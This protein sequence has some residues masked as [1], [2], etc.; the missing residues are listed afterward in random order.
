M[1]TYCTERFQAQR[2]LARK[3]A[4]FM[5]VNEIVET[6]RAELRTIIPHAMEACVLLL[7]PDAKQYTRPLQCAL[8]DRPVNCLMCKRSRP[9][10]QKAVKQGKAVVFHEGS[11]VLRHDSSTVDIG[12][13]AAMPVLLNGEVVAVLSVVAVPEGHFS[14]RDFLFLKDFSEALSN[15]MVNARKHWETTKEKI[16]ISQMLAHLAPFVPQSVRTMVETNP[17]LLSQEK[18]PKDVSILF[19][20]LEGYTALSQSHPEV[21]VN[22]LVERL[23]SGFVDPIQ[24]SR[25]DINETSG[26]GLMIIFKEDDA[27]TNAINSVKAAFEIHERAAELN[28]GPA[29]SLEQVNVKMGINSGQALLGMTRFKGSL[30]TRMTYTAS[31]P[32]TNIAARLASFA[33]GG[34]ILIGEETVRLIQGLWPIYD[35]GEAKLKGIENPVRVFSLTAPVS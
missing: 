23:F 9:A 34:E 7:D 15:V 32:V 8:Y 12:P 17:E 33:K 6:M 24:R 13:E 4:P 16:R 1:D 20:D 28:P 27:R 2:R 18:Q 35:K 31:G 25:G 30:G 21:E 10:V 3:I 14:R 22:R 29:S 11:P 26:D 19:L 5:E